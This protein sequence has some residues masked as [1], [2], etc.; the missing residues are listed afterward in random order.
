MSFKKDLKKLLK[1][2]K[3]EFL[4]KDERQSFY[5]L[6]LSKYLTMKERHED[7]L[8]LDNES[9][10][11]SFGEVNL[12]AAGF[13]YDKKTD[14]YY[15]KSKDEWKKRLS[16][17]NERV[18]I[19]DDKAASLEEAALNGKIEVV[20]SAEQKAIN[21]VLDENRNLGTVVVPV[22]TDKN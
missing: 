6:I 17:L 20:L 12:E 19:F 2:Y 11:D 10:V 18:K 1:K 15:M 8:I 21:E 3:N 9:I 22:M 5:E 14:S 7:L 16:K 4:S 13:K